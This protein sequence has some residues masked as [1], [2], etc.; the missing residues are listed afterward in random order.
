MTDAA[1][2]R[3]AHVPGDEHVDDDLDP[4]D[5]R[6]VRLRPILS[7]EDRVWRHPAEV[8]AEQR[9]KIDRLRTR[10]RWIAAG[11]M[12]ILVSTIAAL[13]LR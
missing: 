11:A 9:A 2:L 12:T 5:E 8:G 1:S 6:P 13:L 4:D 10:R 7:P 3:F